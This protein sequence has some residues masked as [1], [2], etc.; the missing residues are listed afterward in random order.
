MDTAKK[1]Y[2]EKVKKALNVISDWVFELKTNPESK[3]CKK[4]MK[5]IQSDFYD[6]GKN[7]W[8]SPEVKQ[9]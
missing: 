1:N 5:Q 3:L 7:P 4:W 8:K 9:D 2:T 6:E